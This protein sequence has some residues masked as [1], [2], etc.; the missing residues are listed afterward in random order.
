[1]GGGRLEPQ[2]VLVADAPHDL[3]HADPRAVAVILRS[4]EAGGGDRPRAVRA[5]PLGGSAGRLDVAVPEHFARHERHAE[6]AE[7]YG[8]AARSPEHVVALDRAAARAV[9]VE[10][11]VAVRLRSV[12]EDAAETEA[13]RVPRVEVDLGPH[14][15]SP[16]LDRRVVVA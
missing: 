15:E 11:R 4:V 12:V 8:E 6:A 13:Q 7:A 5:R 9:V 16:A 1:V 2:S 10:L 3:A 14:L